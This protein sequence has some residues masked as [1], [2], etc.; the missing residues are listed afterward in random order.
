MSPP[1]IDVFRT[2]CGAAAPLELNVSG[3]GYTGSERRVFENPF[4]LIGRQEHNCLRLE[5]EAVSRRHA[6]LQQL[7]GR[8]FCVDLGSRAGI[9]WGGEIRSA[10][11]LRPQQE[12]QIGPFTLE[13]ARAAGAGDSLADRNGEDWDPLQ[14]RADDT[15][16]LPR[17]TL[18]DGN[19]ILSRFCMN[20]ALV[21]V[22]SAPSC[23]IRLRDGAISKY[24][25]SLVRTPQ[26]VW[27]IDLHSESGARVNGQSLHW[28]L[29][30]ERDRFQVG[31]YV[32]RIEYPEGGSETSSSRLGEVSVGTVV[33]PA[34]SKQD[35]AHEH[36]RESEALR[37]QLAGS[38]AEG[39][40]LREQVHALEV[41]VAEVAG[42]QARLQKA[43]AGAVE[44]ESVR[45]ERDRWQ[46]EAQDLQA[47]LAAVSA[48][49]EE[50][51]QRDVA[52][53]SEQLAQ[54]RAE[55][56]QLCA[57]LPQLESR[58]SVADS[59]ETQLQDAGTEMEQ[60][61][62]Q[63][64]A[65]ELR[66]ADGES[67][68]G[69]C[70]RLREQVRALEIHVAEMASLQNR[71]HTAEAS[72]ADL[73]SVRG[74]RD[75]GQAEV[76]DLQAR[77]AAESAEREELCQRLETAQQHVVEVREAIRAAEANLDQE[78]AALQR[79]HADHSAQSTEHDA[80]LQRLH[81]S[82]EELARAQDEARSLQ[83]RLDKALKS[84][85]DV[86]HLSEQLAQVRAEH[87]HLSGRL[88]HLE[89]RASAAES[90]E[91]QLQDVGAERERLGEQVRA[92]EVQLAEIANLQARLQAAEASAGELETVRGERDRWQAEVQ[93]IQARLAAE[94]AEREQWRQR[95]E[96]V[97]Q[98]L[99]EEREAVDALEAHLDQERTALQR[100][101]DDL[102]A[103]ST[104]HEAGLQR[105]Q[106][107]QDEL[108]RAQDEARALQARLDETLKGQQDVAALGEQLAQVRAEHAQLC[109]RLPHLED[110]T[111]AA[112]R[113]EAEL[114]NTGAERERLREQVRALEIHVAEMAGLQAR[115]QTAEGSAAELES[116]RGERDRW[117]AEAHNLQARLAAEPAD[118]Q[119]L[120]RLLAEVQAGQTE[121]DQLQAEHQTARH[122]AEQACARVSEL[123]RV[124]AEAA[125]AR[126][127]ALEEAR[128][129]WE[130]ERQALEARLHMEAQ[131]HAQEIQAA[132]RDGQAR[133]VA[134]RQKWR[135]QLDGAESQ[136]VWERGMFQEQTN[137]LREQAARLKAERARLAAQLAQAQQRPSAEEKRS[138]DL[139]GHAAEPEPAPPTA[140]DQVFVQIS[141][142]RPG[143]LPQPVRVP[144]SAAP[145]EPAA[146][147][148]LFGRQRS[149]VEEQRRLGAIAQ[150]FQAAWGDAAAGQE[151]LSTTGTTFVPLGQQGAEAT[152]DTGREKEVEQPSAASALP[153]VPADDEEVSVSPG[154]S[155]VSDASLG[156]SQPA[157]DSDG[158]LSPHETGQ[159]KSRQG[160]LRQIFGFVRGK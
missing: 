3:P 43:E 135:E 156:E 82:Q 123:E 130:T 85:Q 83:S 120:D 84:Q 95:L 7:G 23:R 139:A 121:R 65:V 113:L 145:P 71:L 141:S 57:R 107:F 27:L 100:V 131:T 114:Q 75:R 64:R 132:V 136:L 1:T 126:E 73:E 127:K 81:E 88:P 42:L 102:S 144:S 89:G 86:E 133:A 154:P 128:A 22:G 74:E 99:I 68:R 109:A 77:L 21:L 92:L 90:L 124:L 111:G 78:R 67:V 142:I 97:Q 18:E 117:H 129:F 13:L 94:S 59:L 146:P 155:D 150:E 104:E 101:Q 63:L 19:K 51:H 105:L 37:Q 152:L 93:D 44:L 138:S 53:L 50:L 149:T 36:Q 10:G 125:A 25:C 134:E 58:A 30:K 40:R 61:R 157:E 106:E 14:D 5:D 29:L 45:G 31:P 66:A 52:P 15:R 159:P 26:G 9:R 158:S 108:A 20:R 34:E 28:A 80:A 24:H 17:I 38:Q 72:A 153:A 116:V 91:V 41:Q 12:I 79:A 103:R 137:L 35:Q 143:H 119:E 112:E 96:T 47:R 87:A 46:G 76:Q 151:Q 54:V 98:Q 60:L 11:W 69:E 16:L 2:S 70:E 110:R 6:Y 147:R 62:E 48:E 33:P 55:H 160:F 39:D 118:Q 140:R 122:S 32:L 49:R 148:P 4:L 115:L 56:S 8:V